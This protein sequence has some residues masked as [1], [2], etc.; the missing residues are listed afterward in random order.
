MLFMVKQVF[1]V[2]EVWSMRNVDTQ[3]KW[4]ERGRQRAEKNFYV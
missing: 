4:G 3:H 1:L 2:M